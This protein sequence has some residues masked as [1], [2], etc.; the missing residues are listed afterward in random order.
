MVP[1]VGWGTL[2]EAE[3]LVDEALEE[4]EVALAE[5]L[6]EADG[7]VLADASEEDRLVGPL[8]DCADAE[9]D[10]V[11]LADASGAENPLDDCTD[12]LAEELREPDKA[13]LADTSEA[14]ELIEPLDT[15]V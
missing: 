12:A 1:V 11:T 13:A 5:E 2:G 6:R 15:C 4:C 14:V 7:V 10:R 8:E 3:A 9:L